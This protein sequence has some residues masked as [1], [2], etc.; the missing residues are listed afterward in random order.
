MVP[1]WEE[2]QAPKG[3][4]GVGWASSR[5]WERNCRQQVTDGMR[6]SASVEN[7]S[8]SGNNLYKTKQQFKSTTHI[9]AGQLGNRSANTVFPWAKKNE[10]QHKA[11]CN[12][13]YSGL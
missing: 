6:A 3:M 12:K 5:R 13:L 4:R 9:M 1:N 11:T 7:N 2:V 8:L 10:L